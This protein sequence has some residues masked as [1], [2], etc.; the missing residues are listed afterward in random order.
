MGVCLRGRMVEVG[1]LPQPAV[2]VA[3]PTA[4][5]PAPEVPVEPE[6]AVAE[7]ELDVTPPTEAPKTAPDTLVAATFGLLR[8][9]P[10]GSVVIAGSG[11]PGSEVEVYS[12]DQLLGKAKVEPS[13]D[14]VL[15]PDAPIPPGGTELTLA[16]A[17]KAG[18][19]LRILRRRR[20]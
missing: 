5:T 7:P 13:G 1:I 6:V 18:P 8:A 12:N 3:E 15:V 17:G 4:A 10:D 9:E 19:R 2:A 20:R 11:T 14:W 16:E